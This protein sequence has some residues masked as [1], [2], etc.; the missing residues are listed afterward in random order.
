MAKDRAKYQKAIKV[1]LAYN[2]AER[3]KDAFTAFRVAIGEFPHDAAAYAGLGEACLGLKQLDRALDCFKL[4]ARYSRGDIRYLRSVADIQERQ[5]QLAE[6]ARTYLAIGEILLKQRHL[7]EAIGNWERSI[8]LDSSLLG[9]HKRLATVFQRL[10]RK[11]DAVREYLAIARILQLR[12]ENKKA[13][14]MCQAALRLD[15]GNEDVLT[16]V[17][18]IRHGEAALAEPV[19]EA[20]E[21][22]PATGLSAE[23]QAEADSLTETV[24]QM[25][26]IFEAERNEQSVAEQEELSDPIEKARRLAQEELAAELFRDEDE[27]EVDAN[28]LS[29]L[30]RDALLGQAMDFETRGHI[31]DAIGCYQRAIRGGLKLPAA[32]FMLGL[33]FVANQQENEAKKILALTANNPTY[34]QASKLALAGK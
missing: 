9:S 19:E 15:P 14:Q 12:G 10:N 1:G 7:E 17:E 13:L 27:A 3:W 8:R 25:A 20:V 4:A 29:K 5:G 6:A 2:K 32:Y 24:R 22:E 23:E 18:L 16:A 34:L 26:A 11:R 31:D 33:L 21:S 30:E 28:S